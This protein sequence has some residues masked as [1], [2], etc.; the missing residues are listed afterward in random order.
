M[1][2]SEVEDTPGAKGPMSVFEEQKEARMVTQ[3]ETSERWHIRDWL[4]FRCSVVS[5]SLRPYGLQHA[6]LLGPSPSP[7][8]CSNSCLW[9]GDAIQSSCPLLSPLLLSSIFP[10]IRVFANE[11]ALLIRWPKYW[12]FSFS[13]R[14]SHEYSRLISVSIDW[15]DLL[16]VQ[17]TLESLFQHHS[18]KA[19]TL[20]RSAFFIV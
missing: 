14:Y 11:S 6:R 2:I 20:W 1:Q 5:D 19:S 13:I 12:S 18:L 7:E 17:G 9:V 3:G 8:A 4:L 16:A 10:N 15:F